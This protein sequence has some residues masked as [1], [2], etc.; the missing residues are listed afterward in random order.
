MRQFKTLYCYEMKKIAIRKSTW[1][2][3][4][5]IIFYFISEQSIYYIEEAI[6]KSDSSYSEEEEFN[7][8]LLEMMRRDIK[9]AKALSGR[10]LDDSLLKERNDFINGL[11][12]D[13]MN[14]RDKTYAFDRYRTLT[15]II[16]NYTM[17][18]PD[19]VANH[20]DDYDLAA[21]N[22]IRQENLKSSYDAY[23]L[24][25]K[26]KNYW[27]AREEKVKKPIILQY[28]AF[29]E[30]FSFMDIYLCMF[31]LTF[32]I[33]VVI[34]QIFAEEHNKRTDQLI[35]SSR[36]GKKHSYFAK[37]SSGITFTLLVSAFIM[38]VK[39]LLDI[40]FYGTEGSNA[41]ILLGMGQY[42]SNMTFGQATLIMIGILFLAAILTAVLA[43]IISERFR[44]SIA[45][46]A[47]II[48]TMFAAS[49]VNIPMRFR[50]PSQIWSYFPINLIH[51][52][53]GFF[54]L[55]L[56]SIGGL[57]LTSWQFAPLIYVI[58]GIILVIIGKRIYC[59]YQVS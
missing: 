55:R 46:I 18:T 40:S 12:P 20:I 16:A 17:T 30:A 3:L 59:K 47:V 26:E 44:S 51:F 37:I 48:A 5:L 56:I 38:L 19:Y 11:K 41:S 22:E 54:D 15:N 9:N 57:N 29:F 36:L 33:A 23:K 8:T 14:E 31:V 4:A 21:I 52:S 45:A 50:L 28:E 34:S 24:S 32:W 35:L 7:E 49:I 42:S 27:Q 58:L 1:V 43:M 10:A 25:D 13:E 53:K 2:I 39:A 6:N